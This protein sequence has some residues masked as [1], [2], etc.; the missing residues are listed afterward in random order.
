[1]YS[2]NLAPGHDI[3]SI[4]EIA[5]YLKENKKIKFIIVGDGWKFQKIKQMIDDAKSGNIMLLPSQTVTEFYHSLAAADI[6][7][8]TISEG[9]SEL[10]VPSKTFNLLAAGKP[11][12]C[13]ASENSELSQI[14]N[15]YCV[16]KCFRANEIKEMA[17]F[18][19]NLSNNKDTYN[20]TQ[21]N[22]LKCAQS[23][24]PFGAKRFVQAY[25]AVD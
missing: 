1:M 20:T 6:G 15:Q 19:I 24:S 21:I 3:E 22:S 9:N 10:S 14:V 23:Y 2:G 12:L 4:V 8:V 5:S 13:I 11:L 17:D 16:G 18:V 7:I 25:N